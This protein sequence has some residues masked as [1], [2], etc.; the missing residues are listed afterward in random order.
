MNKLLPNV[1]VNKNVKKVDNNK[2][3]YYGNDVN[4]NTFSDEVK[5]VLIRKKINDIFTSNKFIYKAK[6]VITLSSGDKTYTLIARDNTKLLTI[7]NEVINISDILDIK[8]VE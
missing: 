8:Y 1:F 6:V 2:E 7:D 4:N 3:F 5:S